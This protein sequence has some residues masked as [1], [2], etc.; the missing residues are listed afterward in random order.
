MKVV[1]VVQ[2]RTVPPIVTAHAFCASPDIRV[3]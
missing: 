3:S 2:L 1:P